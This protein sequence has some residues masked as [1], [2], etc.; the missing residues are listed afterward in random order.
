VPLIY[1]KYF[2]SCS[3]IAEGTA[4]LLIMLTKHTPNIGLTFSY[5]LQSL[6]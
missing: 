3:K 2:I 4:D 5:R 1:F 6:V